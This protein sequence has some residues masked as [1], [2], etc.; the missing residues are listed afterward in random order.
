MDRN[1]VKLK[2][3]EIKKKIPSLDRITVSYEGSG[4]SFG[5]FNEYD[6]EQT[7]Q[8]ST[9]IKDIYSTKKVKNKMLTYE[10]IEEILVQDLDIND[11]LWF[12]LD[13]SDADFNN[14]GSRG[15]IIIDLNALSIEVDNTYIYQEESSSGGIFIDLKE[16]E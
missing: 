4:D 2:L 1:E 11:L 5:D 6:Y 15:T 7:K 13:K 3:I 12:A 8:K 16:D 10:E 9:D 14:G